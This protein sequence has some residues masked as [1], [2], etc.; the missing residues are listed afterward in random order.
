[1]GMLLVID[2]IG[3]EAYKDV[4]QCAWGRGYLCAADGSS[5]WTLV[6]G[7]GGQ[8][9]RCTDNRDFLALRQP[10]YKPGRPPLWKIP[11]HQAYFSIQGLDN[12]VTRGIM[13]P[14][15]PC[16]DGGDGLPE[17]VSKLWIPSQRERPNS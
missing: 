12:L 10:L 1:M 15:T 13:V 17:D 8:M 7:V 4:Q 6:D 16:A 2:I 9:I 3:G 11:V 14:H 5:F